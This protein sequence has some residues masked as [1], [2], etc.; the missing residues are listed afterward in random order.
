VEF[1]IYLI[2][3]MVPGTVIYFA[4]K[5]DGKPHGLALLLAGIFT[6]L[7]AVMLTVI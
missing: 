6:V 7:F 3:G 1:V 5:R 4:Y 2:A